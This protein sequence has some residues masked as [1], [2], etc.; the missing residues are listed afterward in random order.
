MVEKIEIA[1]AFCD[2]GNVLSV[3]PFGHGNVNDTY[4]VTSERAGLSSEFVLQRINKRVFKCPIALM[5]NMHIVTEHVLGVLDNEN[6]CSDRA[7]QLPRVIVARD[8]KDCVVDEDGEYWRAITKIKHA[9]TL[10][11][12]VDAGHAF[13]VGAV[14]GKFHCCVSDLPCSSL[15]DTLPGFHITPR[16]FSMLDET[17]STSAGMMRLGQTVE[18]G[19][20]L[21]YLR[22]RRSWCSV[23]EDAKSH[24][25]LKEQTIHGD[26]KT[27]NIMIDD[28]TGRGVGIIDLDTVKAGLIHYDLGD[29]LRS[30]CNPLG[31]M[32]RDINAVDFELDYCSAVLEGYR[33]QI[34]RKLTDA[35]GHYLYD[36]ILLIA[37]EQA[38]RFFADYIA[39]DVYYKVCEPGLNFRRAQV[40]VQLCKSIES[41][42]SDIRKIISIMG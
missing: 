1:R 9:H 33:S 24:G 31:E 30:S 32:T 42:E 39:G 15:Y 29:C 21:S 35:E 34:G 27:G 23:L 7:W 37:F 25:E 17:L 16:Y 13:E 38:L 40:Q 5:A 3:S 2:G 41:K 18:A 11:C 14:L 28:S 6:D 10:E 22:S 26:P 4:L 12:I 20:V 8:G 36:S 19:E